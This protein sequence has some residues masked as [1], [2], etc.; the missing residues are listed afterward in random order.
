MHY[1]PWWNPAAQAQ[2]TDRAYR[3]GQSK[4]VFVYNLF[5]S[6]SVEERVL[7]LQDKKR[8]LSNSLLGDAAT[9]DVA[10]PVVDVPVPTAVTSRSN[11]SSG[12]ALAPPR[13]SSHPLSEDD[14]DAL[15]APLEERAST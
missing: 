7:A 5:V 8:W 13:T 6:G 3:I 4:P 14:V 10:G 2:A 12:P 1:D 11:E 15:L 9:A